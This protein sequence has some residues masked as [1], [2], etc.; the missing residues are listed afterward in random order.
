M[1]FT[2]SRP[3]HMRV[4]GVLWPC[5]GDSL[6][7]S[8]RPLYPRQDEKQTQQDLRR[9]PDARKVGSTVGSVTRTPDFSHDLLCHHVK[10]VWGELLKLCINHVLYGTLVGFWCVQTSWPEESTSPM[11]TG[12]YSTTPQVVPGKGLQFHKGLHLFCQRYSPV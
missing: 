5:V 12:S 8:R 10:C 4:G 7:E 2:T 6:Q 1:R 9:L 3:Q 11:S